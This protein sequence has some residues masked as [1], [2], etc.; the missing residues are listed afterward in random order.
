MRLVSR[1]HGNHILPDRQFGVR[2]VEDLSTVYRGEIGFER[3]FFRR[4]ARSVMV[5]G[6][7]LSPDVIAAWNRG[8]DSGTAVKFTHFNTGQQAV[9]W[10]ALEAMKA[11]AGLALP[12]QLSMEVPGT[13][14]ACEFERRSDLPDNLFVC[15]GISSGSLVWERYATDAYRRMIP[16][17]DGPLIERLGRVSA[18][19]ERYQEAFSVGTDSDQNDASIFVVTGDGGVPALAQHMAQG[20]EAMVFHADPHPA[21]TVARAFGAPT[22]SELEQTW[23]DAMRQVTPLAAAQVVMSSFMPALAPSAA[24]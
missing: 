24:R 21:D 6:D 23:E 12:D 19:I 16:R 11:R 15:E 5:A 17:T 10:T 1:F 8:S 4:V 2:T 3:N 18:A 22:L 13:Q 9:R 14:A 20:Y 7:Q